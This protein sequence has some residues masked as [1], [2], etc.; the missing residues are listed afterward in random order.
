MDGVS[1]DG[2]PVEVYLALPADPDLQVIR[3]AMSERCSVLDL[4]AGVG[5][6][7]NPLAADGHRVVAVD[8]SP[9]L[10]AHVHGPT[11]VV[12]DIWSLDLAERFDVVLALSH[13]INSVSRDRRMRLL[14][15]CRRHVRD[16]GRVLIQRHEPGGHRQTDKAS[17]ARSPSDSMTSND[18]LSTSQRP[19][20]TRSM[21]GHG[22]NVG[23]QPPL[24]TLNSRLSPKGP[25][26][27]SATSSTRPA[28]GSYSRRPN[29]RS[30]AIALATGVGSTVVSALR[31]RAEPP[32]GALTLG[33]GAHACTS[34]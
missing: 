15:V 5:R 8:N 33:G 3:S 17:W 4:G 26:S 18:M 1:P 7:A 19:R 32:L 14:A 28:I 6:L 25:A 2:S 10:R 20:R 27:S 31:C 29:A 12:A 21:T 23:K 13:L 16:G 24:M 11:T 9:E 34:C 22:R 30:G